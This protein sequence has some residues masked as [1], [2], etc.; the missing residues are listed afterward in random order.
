MF[1]IISAEFEDPPV[2]SDPESRAVSFRGEI[3]IIVT[4]DVVAG[5]GSFHS[6]SAARRVIARNRRECGPG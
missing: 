5:S 2:H 4:G 1:S 6:P 3:R